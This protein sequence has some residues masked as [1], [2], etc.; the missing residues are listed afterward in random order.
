[1][2]ETTPVSARGDTRPTAASPAEPAGDPIKAVY[3][4]FK[5]LDYLL[6]DLGWIV[7]ETSPTRCILYDLWQAI[8]AYA[9]ENV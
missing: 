3:D 4:K 2:T 5:H 9:M 8:R 6:S 7:R 1:M